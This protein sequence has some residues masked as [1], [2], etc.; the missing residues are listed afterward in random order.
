MATEIRGPILSV[1][2]CERLGLIY[3][4]IYEYYHFHIEKS[5]TNCMWRTYQVIHTYQHIFIYIYISTNGCIYVY[6][7]PTGYTCMYVRRTY[8]YTLIVALIYTIFI[9]GSMVQCKGQQSITHGIHTSTKLLHQITITIISLSGTLYT[10]RL[11]NLT[12]IYF[13]EFYPSAKP[14]LSLFEA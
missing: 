9:N 6:R 7:A 3:P 2:S 1:G 11:F 12:A 5:S 13:G 4:T 10:V 8:I 14:V